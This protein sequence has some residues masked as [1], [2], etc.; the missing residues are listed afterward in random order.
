MNPNREPNSVLGVYGPPPHFCSMGRVSRLPDYRWEAM[1]AEL[2][3]SPESL[4]AFDRLEE[5]VD[6]VSG[7]RACGLWWGNASE[8]TTTFALRSCD[9]CASPTAPTLSLNAGAGNDLYIWPTDIARN[10][11]ELELCNRC[12]EDVVTWLR[13]TRMRVSE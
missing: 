3:S 5:A 6:A 12:I 2:D 8:P 7:G 9:R 10:R 4:G 11:T 13:N 1:R